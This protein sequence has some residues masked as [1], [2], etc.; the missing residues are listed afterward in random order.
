M[1]AVRVVIHRVRMGRLNARN[2]AARELRCI[3][4]WESAAEGV[5]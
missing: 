2:G 1:E 5:E 3:E 4:N